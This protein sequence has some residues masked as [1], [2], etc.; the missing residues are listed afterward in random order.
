MLKSPKTNAADRLIP[1]TSSKLDEIEPK[2]THKGK[3]ND[4]Q[5]KKSKTLSEVKPV[6]NIQISG[7]F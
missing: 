3:E 4:Q 7:V 1:R 6:E 5:R 2:A